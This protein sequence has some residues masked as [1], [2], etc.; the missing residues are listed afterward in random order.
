MGDPCLG[1]GRVKITWTNDKIQEWRQ[2]LGYV[3]AHLVKKTLEASTHYYP[4]VRHERKVTPKKSAVVRFTILI[5]PI[6]GVCRNKETF[7][8][9]LL[10]DTY[11][12]KFFWA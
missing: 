10:E 11:A 8:V 1:T 12:E 4:G 6:R 5:D 9:D 3:S 7:S 2:H